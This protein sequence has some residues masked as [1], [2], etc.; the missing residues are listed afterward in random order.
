MKAYV[1]ATSIDGRPF[2]FDLDSLES[3]TPYTFD[4]D[5]KSG[6]YLTF[7]S[8]SSFGVKDSCEDLLKTM[9]LVG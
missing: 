8:G 7:T 3:F 6:S 1:K 5:E 9:E 2:Y 4:E